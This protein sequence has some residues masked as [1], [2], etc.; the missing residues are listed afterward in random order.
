VIARS[1][2]C[3]RFSK[4]QFFSLLSKEYDQLKNDPAVKHPEK[5]MLQ[6]HRKAGQFQ[7][8]F[9]ESKW[10]G[11]RKREQWDLFCDI[12]PKQ[13]RRCS[14]LPNIV[15]NLLNVG[16]F[17]HT[18][19]KHKESDG[20]RRLPAPLAYAWES[21]LIER[22]QLGEEVTSDFAQNVFMQM[23]EEW[24][25]KITDLAADLRASVGPSILAKHDEAIQ[26]EASDEMV[27]E[28]QSQ[29]AAEVER[30]LSCLQTCN[31]SKNLRGIQFL[32]HS[33]GL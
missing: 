22:M 26:D 14:E 17:K 30:A 8:C 33:A 21:L 9:A 3:F 5:Y 10:G 16:K 18:N 27:S 7:G 2:D 31:I 20:I 23:V 11:K 29:A 24:N 1:I 13:A 15:K 19:G 4:T 6:K 32:G 28:A 25:S 12:A